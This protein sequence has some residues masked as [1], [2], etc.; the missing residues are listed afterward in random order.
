VIR[1][2]HWKGIVGGALGGLGLLA[3]GQQ[4][5]NERAVTSAQLCANDFQNCVLPVLS[6]QIRRKGQGPTESI[7]CGQLSCHAPN[8]NG[9]AF[10]LDVTNPSASLDAV[11]RQVDFTNPR[12]S[13]VLV[14]P[15]QDDV[16]PSP[17]AAFH[18][19]GDIFPSL[20]DACYVTIYNWISNQVGDQSS[21]ACGSCIP[22]ADTYLSCG[23]PP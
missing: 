8:G 2:C 3:C 13:R 19:G 6:G 4:V 7:S 23:Y 18:G 22:V 21:P 17:T 15:T 20:S 9:G 12:D 14:E 5:P 16:A 10:T 1:F 11:L